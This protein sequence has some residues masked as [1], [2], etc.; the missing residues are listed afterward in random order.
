[1]AIN[2][3][4]TVAQPVAQLIANTD[5]FGVPIYRKN[6]YNE[7]DPDWTKAY[8]GTNPFLVE[9]AKWLN[10]V[11]GGDNVVK[12]KADINPAIVEHLF[13]S[14]LGGMGKTFNK[15][16]TTFSM[17]FNK[18]A[19]EWRNVPVLSSFYQV[20]NDRTSGSQINREYFE[21]SDEA[22]KIAHQFSGYKKQ[23]R[24]GA[25][26]YAEKLDELMKSPIF[27]RYQLVN[28]YNKA[29]TKL[30]TALKQTT[31]P[32]DREQIETAIMELKAEML[33]ELEKLDAQTNEDASK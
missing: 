20:P 22:D 21:V 23:L 29:I 15:T 9:S 4:P 27:A 2:L 28:G 17:L 13:E 18:D 26:E 14:Y 6:D 11:T 19:R 5:Y 33:A 12:G 31:D 8:K 24:M 3:S 30:N 10:E 7:L 1:M 25:M 16:V 32:T